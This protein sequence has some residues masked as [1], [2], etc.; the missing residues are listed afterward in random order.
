M[1]KGKIEITVTKRQKARMSFN[2]LKNMDS[3]RLSLMVDEIEEITSRNAVK[4]SIS[5]TDATMMR[6]I[7]QQLICI[8]RNLETNYEKS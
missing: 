2:G 7:Q 3:K 8:V 5:D 1:I 4:G 6:S